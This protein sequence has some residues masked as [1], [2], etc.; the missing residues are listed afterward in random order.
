M[1]T[2]IAPSFL[3]V[4]SNLMNCELGKDTMSKL[5]SHLVPECDQVMSA[6]RT[7]LRNFSTG[8]LGVLVDESAQADDITFFVRKGLREHLFKLLRHLMQR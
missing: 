1:V 6:L 5:C 7:S 8:S 2:F 3:A 4:K